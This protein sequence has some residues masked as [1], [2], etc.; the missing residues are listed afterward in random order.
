V[1]QL[2]LFHQST[3]LLGGWAASRGGWHEYLT[4]YKLSSKTVIGW[5]F[6]FKDKNGIKVRQQI[7]QV[8]ITVW[9]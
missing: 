5:Y 8:S 4:S 7:L 1:Q 3:A 6:G 9:L 2:P